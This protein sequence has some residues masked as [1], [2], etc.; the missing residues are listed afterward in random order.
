MKIIADNLQITRS[1]LADAL[2]HRN[3]DPFQ[4]LVQAMEAGGAEA[5]DLVDA[6]DGAFCI[7]NVLPHLPTEGLAGFLQAIRALLRPGGVWLFQTVNF[8]PILRGEEYV[9]PEINLPSEQLSFLRFPLGHLA[10]KAETRALAP[11][12]AHAVLSTVLTS[13]AAPMP[14][15]RLAMSAAV[16]SLDQLGS[17]P[18]PLLAS[19]RVAWSI[20]AWSSCG[21]RSMALTA[22]AS[23]GLKSR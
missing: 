13:A 21:S 15:L 17:C 1:D 3:P 23:S 14:A 20:R 18:T 7:G 10:S 5:V 8:D 22:S 19:M 6:A 12:A 4:V 9:F 11:M 16:S 2:F